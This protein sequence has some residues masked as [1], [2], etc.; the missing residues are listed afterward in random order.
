M[1]T[2]PWKCSNK[3]R[4]YKDNRDRRTKKQRQE[5]LPA[6]I[7][8]QL[9]YTG[10][11]KTALDRTVRKWKCGRPWCLCPCRVR[12]RVYA[13]SRVY[14][15]LFFSFSIYGPVSFFTCIFIL[16][17][18]F[19]IMFK[20]HFDAPWRHGHEAW[21]QYGYA[22]WMHNGHATWPC[23]METWTRSMAM[24]MQHGH[25]HTAWTLIHAAPTWT[26]SIDLTIQH[27]HGHEAWTWTFTKDMY[28]GHGHSASTYAASTWTW[29]CSMDIDLQQTYCTYIDTAGVWR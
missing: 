21:K 9:L 3:G 7:K 26:C 15:H 4:P 2:Q 1:T 10:K 6:V 13:H 17:F 25:G 20:Q 18:M 28:R 23:S 12:V 5:K 11:G 19:K 8:G 27:W 14:V 22:T 24:D 29:T 16:M